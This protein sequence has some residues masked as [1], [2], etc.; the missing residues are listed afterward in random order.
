[1]LGGSIERD[2]RRSLLGALGLRRLRDQARDLLVASSHSRRPEADRASERFYPPRTDLALEGRQSLVTVRSP[3]QRREAG[4]R[5]ARPSNRYP[6]TTPPSGV[7]LGASAFAARFALA[8]VLL[9]NSPAHQRCIRP[10]NS[11]PSV[12]S[13]A[14]ESLAFHAR[15]RSA[16]ISAVPRRSRAEE[17]GLVQRIPSSPVSTLP[18]PR[19]SSTPS[20]RPI[21]PGAGS[22]ET[23]G[24]TAIRRVPQ[25]RTPSPGRAEPGVRNEKGGSGSPRP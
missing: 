10:V 5:H 20:S 3:R 16:R 2:Y 6:L 21:L 25:P 12:N 1:V 17:R 22:G 15:T 14:D 24:K 19:K 8:F 11:C 4:P 7:C 13:S 9:K 23:G 18:S